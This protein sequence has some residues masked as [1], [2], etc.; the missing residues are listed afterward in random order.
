MRAGEPLTLVVGRQTAAGSPA[1]GLTV[2][3]FGIGWKKDGVTSAITTS[4]TEVDT[5]GG[6]REY[7]I[8]I[9]I[10]SGSPYR[11]HG[12]VTAVNTI[13]IIDGGIVDCEIENNDLDSLAALLPIIPVAQL[14]ATSRTADPQTLKIIANRYTPVSFNVR[15]ATG[16]VVDLSTYTNFRFSVWDKTHATAIYTLSGGTGSSLGVAAWT[17]PETAA[18]FAQMATAVAAGQDDITLYWD[19]TGDLGGVAGQSQTVL[20][21]PLIMHR[22]ESPS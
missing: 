14:S 2:A 16:A 9:T 3:D 22:N 7:R 20:Y 10:P 1:T 17:I 8:G 6:W 19:F 21:G 5:V 12:R 13:D 4:C 11:L 18:F 15:D